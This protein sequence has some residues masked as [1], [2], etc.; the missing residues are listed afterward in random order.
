[1]PT[2]SFLDVSASIIGPG[3]SASLAAGAGAEEGGIT[4]SASEDI[5][6]M[7]VGAGGEVMHSLHANRSGEATVRLLKTSPV[8]K[9]LAQMYALQ[10]AAGSA[11]GQNTIV[12]TNAQ[13][14]DVVS[15][16]QKKKKKAPELTYAKDGGSNEWTFDVGVIDRSLGAGA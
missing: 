8:N 11:H 2:Y 9:V 1:M 3:G 13:S 15:L 14:G 5:N 4:V 10:T 16:Q 7:L 6:T 12:I